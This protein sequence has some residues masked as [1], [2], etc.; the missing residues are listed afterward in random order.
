MHVVIKD[1]E[2]ALQ[3]AE[4]D[5][6][7]AA[8]KREEMRLLYRDA[9]RAREKYSELS[10]QAQTERKRLVQHKEDMELEEVVTRQPDEDPAAPETHSKETAA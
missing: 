6:S 5:R 8:E 10:L 4:V 1:C 7:N 9:F 3:A 2:L